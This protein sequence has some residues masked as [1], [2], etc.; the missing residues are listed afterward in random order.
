MVINSIIDWSKDIKERASV[1]RK[2]KRKLYYLL[3]G[4]IIHSWELKKRIVKVVIEKQADYG[5]Q[6]W[7]R[8]RKVKCGPIKG[9]QQEVMRL[10]RGAPFCMKS[11]QL[12]K[13]VKIK[14]PIKEAREAKKRMLQKLAENMEEERSRLVHWIETTLR[15]RQIIT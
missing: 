10:I 8:D 4:K 12:R 13:K 6:I 3:W 2:T 1:A 7:T 14:E 15:K 9:V 11:I 5:N